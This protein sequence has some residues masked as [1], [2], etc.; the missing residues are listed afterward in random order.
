M[1]AKMSGSSLS[2]L[3]ISVRNVWI[4]W[5]EESIPFGAW[6]NICQSTTGCLLNHVQP[7]SEPAVLEWTQ[8]SSMDIGDLRDN[9]LDSDNAIVGNHAEF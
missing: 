7:K 3:A 1:G 9:V 4:A 2:S 5:T 6:W 8:G